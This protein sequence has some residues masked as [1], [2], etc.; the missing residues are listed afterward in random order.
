MGFIKNVRDLFRQKNLTQEEAERSKDYLKSLYSFYSNGMVSLSYSNLKTVITNGYQKNVDVFSVVNWIAEQGAAIPLVVEQLKGETWEAVP[1][2]PLQKLIDTPNPYQDG[3]EHRA[4]SLTYYLITGNSFTYAPRLETGVNEGQTLEMW[5]M[6]SQYTEI[7]S[8]GWKSPIKGYK[9]MEAQ[10]SVL[11][12]RYEDVMHVKT[13]TLDYGNGQEFWGMS[14]LRAG[15]LALDRSNSNYQASS[16]SFKTMGMAGIIT[17]NSEG[18]PAN[19]TTEQQEEAEERLNESYMG[20]FNKGK[21]MVAKNVD[22]NYTR[23]GL[24]PVDLNLIVDK[25]ATLRDFCNIYNISSIIFNDNE[26]ST[27]NNMSEAKKSAYNDA[28]IP[29]LNRYISKLSAWL[30]A[31]YGD[32]LRIIADTS[33]IPE[34]Q[35]NK[36]EQA[37]RLALLVDRG[38]INRRTANEELGNDVEGVQGMDTYTVPMNLVPIDELTIDPLIEPNNGD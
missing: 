35:T 5:T 2:H 28:V 27:Y 18:M 13:T 26:N 25:R 22:V 12:L 21:T 37:E 3:F 8:G 33:G 6:P 11:P 19:L 29:T 30:A 38:I 10:R 32:D 34:L 24:S 23:I 16:T 1:K 31:S 14:P 20:V 36:K 15:L 4:Q 7:I 9:F 17:E